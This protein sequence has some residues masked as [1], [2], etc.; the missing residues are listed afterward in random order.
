MPANASETKKTKK[1]MKNIWLAGI[2]GT[3]GEVVKA[4][5]P[6]SGLPR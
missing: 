5:W 4:L 1:N 3:Y 6:E 2:P